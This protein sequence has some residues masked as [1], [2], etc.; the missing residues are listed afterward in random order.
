MVSSR[1]VGEAAHKAV[2]IGGF[3][4]ER[5]SKAD[6]DRGA[7]PSC[8][9]LALEARIHKP[10]KLWILG[11]SPRITSS[12]VKGPLSISDPQTSVATDAGRCAFQPC[13]PGMTFAGMGQT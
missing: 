7:K 5:A 6:A 13:E 3:G 11:S 10:L 1:P 2:I 9:I 12:M 4:G 8:V